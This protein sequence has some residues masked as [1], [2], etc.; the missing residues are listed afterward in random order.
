M[1]KLKKILFC[2][3]MTVM[4]F[5]LYAEKQPK[6][7]VD[8][9]EAPLF[10]DPVWHGS[11]DP[12]I[13]W[14]PISKEWNIFYTQRRATLPNHN[15]VDWA[16]G[17]A[18]GIATSK[19]GKEWKYAGTC[20]GYEALENPVKNNCSWWAPCVVFDGTSFHMFVTWVDGIYS[21]WMGKRY[22]KHFTS[23]NGTDW[24]YHSTLK[25]SSVSCIDASVH[26]VGDHWRMW[27]KDE[28]NKSRTWCAQSPDLNNWTVVGPAVTDVAHE[29]PFVW[30]WKDRQPSSC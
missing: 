2:C 4:A 19:D 28:R 24:K 16:H 3:A 1:N 5:N 30:Q 22:M 8:E 20:K 27:Y 17:S 15:G 7:L 13:I 18:I 11:A 21:K 23:T 6:F 14:N 26:K 29:A 10:E 25:L 12:E 9:A